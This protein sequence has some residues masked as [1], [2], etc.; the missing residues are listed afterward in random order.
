MRDINVF[1]AFDGCSCGQLALGKADIPIGVYHA[2]EIDPHAIKV[3]QANFPSTIQLGDVTQVGYRSFNHHIDLMMGGSPCQGFSFAGKQL[4]FDDP[5]SRLFFD[6]IRIRDELKPK[7]VLL[8]N[9]RMSKQSQ[10]VISKYMGC[11]PIK[12]NSSLVSAQSRNRL[13]LSLIHI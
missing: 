9:V 8:E 12:I 2:S 6:F 4:N 13:Y 11:E 5:R 3:T 1:S 7:Y 10:D